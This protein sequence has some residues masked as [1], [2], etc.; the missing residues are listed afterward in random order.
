M[1][2]LKSS[3]KRSSKITLAKVQI[4]KDET[5]KEFRERIQEVGQGEL[6][7]SDEDTAPVECIGICSL[8][9]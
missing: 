9:N 4:F 3:K 2:R 6:V 8:L 7:F 1:K 5:L